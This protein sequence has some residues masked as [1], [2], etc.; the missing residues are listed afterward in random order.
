MNIP[1]KLKLPIALLVLLVKTLKP[2][3]RFP[4][5]CSRLRKLAKWEP[6]LRELATA[7]L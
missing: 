7:D 6:S 3:K 4:E 5:E 2:Q 1:G